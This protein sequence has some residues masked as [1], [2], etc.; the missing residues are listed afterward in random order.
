MKK[1]SEMSEMNDKK[2]FN[3]IIVGMTACRKIKYFLD[4]IENEY[5][6]YLDYIFFNLPDI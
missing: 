2:P 3:M 4:F 5:K 6:N 1:A